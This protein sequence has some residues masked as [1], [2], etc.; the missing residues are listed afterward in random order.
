[1]YWFPLNLTG[2]KKD[3]FVRPLDTQQ[4]STEKF[5]MHPHLKNFKVTGMMT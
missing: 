1:M 4:E 5:P 3:Y 2:D